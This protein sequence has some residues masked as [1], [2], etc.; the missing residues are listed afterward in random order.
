MLFR[1][2][3][4]VPKNSLLISSTTG[5][6]LLLLFIIIIIIIIGTINLAQNVSVIYSAQCRAFHPTEDSY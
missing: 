3:P 2:K 6:L 5:L 4:F 1:G